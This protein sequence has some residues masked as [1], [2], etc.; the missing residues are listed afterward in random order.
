MSSRTEE[1][2]EYLAFYYFQTWQRER[3]CKEPFV[4]Y[5][6]RAT[7]FLFSPVV[8]QLLFQEKSFDITENEED[9][10]LDEDKKKR[11]KKR[12]REGC[13]V[14]KWL[15]VWYKIRSVL[16]YLECLLQS[17][18]PNHK[19]KFCSSFTKTLIIEAILI[20]SWKISAKFIWAC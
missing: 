13:I 20:A 4:Q 3:S 10:S 6:R 7:S 9:F 19:F 14:T 2:L 17:S 16:L 1:I 8:Y 18:Q 12:G 5:I 11:K 15:E